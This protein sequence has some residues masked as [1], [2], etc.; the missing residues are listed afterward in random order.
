MP[1]KFGIDKEQLAYL[2][3]SVLIKIGFED[4]PGHEVS[5]HADRRGRK[6]S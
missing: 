3:T 2:S 5:S 6:A 1:T 4:S